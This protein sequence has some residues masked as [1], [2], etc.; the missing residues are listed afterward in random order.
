MA[1]SYLEK[2]IGKVTNAFNFI[3]DPTPGMFCG[4][5]IG[6]SVITLENKNIK[7]TT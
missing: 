7:N 2:N 6:K 1:E 3:W 4:K 5:I